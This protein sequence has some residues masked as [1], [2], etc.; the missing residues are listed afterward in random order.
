MRFAFCHQRSD[1]SQRVYVCVANDCNEWMC[2]CSANHS[3][4]DKI[5]VIRLLLYICQRSLINDYVRNFAHKINCMHFS[6]GCVSVRFKRHSHS[7]KNS[8]CSHSKWMNGIHCVNLNNIFYFFDVHATTYYSQL[9]D[10]SDWKAT[11]EHTQHREQ[12]IFQRCE[13]AVYSWTEGVLCNL[14]LEP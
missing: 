5:S 3:K 4:E 12:L 10:I 14:M 13:W 1:R 6:I 2:I 8:L 7:L 9:R 11:K